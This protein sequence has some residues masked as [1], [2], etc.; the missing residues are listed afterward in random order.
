ML[1]EHD[2]VLATQESVLVRDVCEVLNAITRTVIENVFSV[3]IRT[4]RARATGDW[5]SLSRLT[6]QLE[7]VTLK[8]DNAFALHSLSDGHVPADR[9]QAQGHK[10]SQSRFVYDPVVNSHG[11]A[12]GSHR[13]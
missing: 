3:L 13:L 6:N 11:D 4:D 9:C 1:D 12:I 8:H 5:Q 7:L 10:R 2:A